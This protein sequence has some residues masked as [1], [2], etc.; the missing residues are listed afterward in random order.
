MFS[1]P[2][3]AAAHYLRQY[4]I[5]RIH[6][7]ISPNIV[8]SRFS[9]W[10]C[11]ALCCFAFNTRNLDAGHFGVHK[12]KMEFCPWRNQISDEALNERGNEIESPH[13]SP[14][15]PSACTRHRL[16]KISHLIVSHL[17]LRLFCC[18]YINHIESQHLESHR[19]GIFLHRFFSFW[20]LVSNP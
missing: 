7:S 1:H 14:P 18:N 20:K 15:L 13:H 12:Q 10:L 4:T 17:V 9:E 3:W 16:D 2:Q 5:A 6:L 8:V 11:I 19:Y